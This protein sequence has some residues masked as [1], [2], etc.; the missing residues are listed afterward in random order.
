MDS[1]GSPTERE[2]SAR[3]PKR[4]VIIGLL[5]STLDSGV[6]E[7]RWSRWRPTVSIGQHE[8]LLVDRLEILHEQRHTRIARLVADDLHTVSPE[9]EVRLHATETADPWDFEEVFAT[10]LDFCSSYPFDLDEEEYLVH[11]TTGTHVAQ[12]CLFLLAESR[13]LPARLLQTSP[14]ARRGKGSKDI[15]GTYHVIDLDLSR[16]DRLAMRFAEEQREGLDFLKAG[17]ATRNET[18]NRRM[19]ELERVA[20]ASTAPILLAGPTGA[21]KT[22]LAR[23]IYDLKKQRGEVVGPF[24]ELNCATLR[25]DAAMSALFGHR[26]GAFTGAI[27]DRPGLLRAADG[28]ILFLD[29]IGELGLDEQAMLLRAIEERRFLPVGSDKEEHSEFQLIAG[30]N[31]DLRKRVREGGFRED[32]LARIDLWT[33]EL[34]GLADRREDIEP[35]LDFELEM[36]TRRTGRKVTMNREARDRFLRFAM[37]G[38]SSWPG[39]FRDLNAAIVRMSTLATGGRIRKEEVDEELSR[40]ERQWGPAGERGADAVTEILGPSAAAKLDRFD[41]IQLE[42][43]LGVCR[44]SRSLSEAGRILFAESQSRRS[45]RN[46]SDRLRK[47]LSRFGIDGGA[48][49]GRSGSY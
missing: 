21:G 27:A 6:S 39:N 11:I 40:L 22:Q 10:L 47:Y 28:G 42:D 1:T 8:E 7:D 20:I 45:S 33:F 9:T 49:V 23:R 15:I 34:P 46:D 13:H 26:R 36:R 44:M 38:T 35:N 2:P 24:V 3:P 5:G 4:R 12:I 37:A 29:E 30:S 31:R 43:V 14:P 18:F 19:E 17:I 25:G 48:V 16:Y 32:L 41:R